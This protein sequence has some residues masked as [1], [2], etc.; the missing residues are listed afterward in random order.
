MKK[1][2]VT[3]FVALLMAGCGEDEET[4]KVVEDDTATSAP[5]PSREPSP[6]PASVSDRPASSGVSRREPPSRG[7]ACAGSDR[8]RTKRRFFS[9][10]AGIAG[11]AE[12]SAKICFFP[13]RELSC[14]GPRKDLNWIS[15]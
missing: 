15:I 14:V 6:A 3:M 13:I 4:T 12:T 7:G 8:S 2:L 5:E 9:G 1:L 10:F 11:I